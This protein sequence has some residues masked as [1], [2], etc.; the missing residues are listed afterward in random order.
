MST[1]AQEQASK[2]G[3]ALGLQVVKATQ[4]Q[5]T[6]QVSYATVTAVHFDSSGITLDVKIQNGY[7]YA[8]P[9]LVECVNARVGDRVM[10]QTYGPITTAIGVVSRGTARRSLGGGTVDA[11]LFE[12][13]STFSGTVTTGSIHTESIKYITHSGGP[14]LCEVAAAVTGAGEYGMAFKF[15]QNDNEKAFWVSTTP[16]NNSGVLRWSASGTVWLPA[17]DYTATLQTAA[18][19][20]VRIAPGDKSLISRKWRDSRL[21]TDGVNQ[22]ARIY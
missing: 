20:N 13:K 5:Q 22:Y 12:W 4:S 15:E 3:R 16:A 11:P 18:W 17:G 6:T 9:C 21:G 8:I 7:L 14:L 19:G 10:L 2:L 1:T